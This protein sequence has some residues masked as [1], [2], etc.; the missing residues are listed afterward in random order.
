MGYPDA[1]RIRDEARQRIADRPNMVLDGDPIVELALAHERHASRLVEVIDT[2]R[3]VG[4]TNYLGDTVEGRGA[5]Y[6]IG[7]AVHDH[8]HSV[9]RNYLREADEAR[10]IATALR[11]ISKDIGDTE[12]E[13][14]EGI[15]MVR[16]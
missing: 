14:A 1:D 9:V 10:T 5:T 2:L 6:N 4:R 13:N 11:Q 15:G 3:E 16:L 7:V 12:L 8:E